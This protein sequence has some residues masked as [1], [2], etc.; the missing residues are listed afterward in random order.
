V[1]AVDGARITILSQDVQVAPR[2]DGHY[3]VSHHG[4]P[5]LVLEPARDYREGSLRPPR[6]YLALAR[7]LG[8]PDR[9]PPGPRPVTL[10][11]VCR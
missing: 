3:E 11:D 1:E 4:N 10:E 2:P 9:W 6:L 7:L 5:W 8:L